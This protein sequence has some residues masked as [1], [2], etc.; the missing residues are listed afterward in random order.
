M[1]V[2]ERQ[3]KI[4][5]QLHDNG[6]VRVKDLAI[7]F[8]VSE[9]CIRKDLATLEGNG[10]LKRSYGGAVLERINVHK[11]NVSQRK[12]Q[13]VS[14]KI[15]IAKCAVSLLHEG[16]MVFLDISTVNIEVAKEIMKQR[17]KITLVTNM[18]E[19]MQIF[20]HPS[21]V[22]LIFIGGTF[23]RGRDGFIGSLTIEN[24]KNFRFDVAFMGVVSIDA[25]ENSVNTYVGDD[26]VTKKAIMERSRASYMLCETKKFAHQGN[27][28]YAKI[29]DFTGIVLEQEPTKEIVKSLKSYDIKL[30]F[31]K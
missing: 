2:Q 24:I 3:S 13:D 23:N 25:Y 10:F 15:K 26:G 22:T 5:E 29:N 28:T 30:Y 31:S 9:D 27:Y 1:F 19:V 17:K 8:E 21:E 20:S 11:E 4:V 7:E 14:K 18:I 16:D 6:F 12:E